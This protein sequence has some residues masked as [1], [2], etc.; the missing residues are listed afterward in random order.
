MSITP[1]TCCTVHTLL[2]D[3]TKLRIVVITEGAMLTV[4]ELPTQPCSPWAFSIRYKSATRLNI[5]DLIDRSTY[6]QPR[7]AGTTWAGILVVA[8]HLA[9][10]E[11]IP[12]IIH[13]RDK[14]LGAPHE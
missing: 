2:D 8:E 1:D 5:E 3:A 13:V 14:R 6:G 10:G 11:H 4:I 7:G 12:D 9:A